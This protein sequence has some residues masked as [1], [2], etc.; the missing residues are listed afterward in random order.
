M[1]VGVRSLSTQG[2]FLSDRLEA[3]HDTIR[4]KA[5]ATRVRRAIT[6]RSC[7]YRADGPARPL[8]R[9]SG[10]LSAHAAG[11]FHGCPGLSRSTQCAP[12]IIVTMQTAPAEPSTTPRDS[13]GA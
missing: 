12:R 4:L 8:H 6:L 5:S 1:I 2:N 3:G 9:P 13:T 10:Q 7:V 11:S